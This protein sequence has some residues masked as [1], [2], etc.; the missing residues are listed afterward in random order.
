MSIQ[1]VSPPSRGHFFA[2]TKTARWECGAK[3]DYA[4]D[5]NNRKKKRTLHLQK[6]KRLSGG[7]AEAVPHLAAYE[8]LR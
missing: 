2:I 7:G 6:S 1:K 3:K 8:N 4:D 5:E